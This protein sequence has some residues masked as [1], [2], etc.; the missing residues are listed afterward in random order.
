MTPGSNTWEQYSFKLNGIIED[1]YLKKLP[2]VCL[3]K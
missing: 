1:A 3:R 2:Q